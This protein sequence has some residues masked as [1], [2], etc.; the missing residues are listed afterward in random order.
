MEQRQFRRIGFVAGKI[1]IEII[2][3]V[4]LQN[5]AGFAH[6]FHRGKIAFQCLDRTEMKPLCMP[7]FIQIAVEP[8]IDIDAFRTA[9]INSKFGG[10]IIIGE[11]ISKVLNSGG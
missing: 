11:V 6:D 3:R 7:G 10:K 2:R 8:G 9:E 4:V 5:P 1:L